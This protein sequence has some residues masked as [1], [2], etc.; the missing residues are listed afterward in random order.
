MLQE[1]VADDVLIVRPVESVSLLGEYHHV[2]PFACLL[3]S[4]GHADGRSDGHV[5]VHLASHEQ[6]TTLQVLGQF[7]GRGYRLAVALVGLSPPLD[8]SGV[9][10]IARRSHTYL[11]EVGIGKHGGDSLKA[12]AAVAVDAN[13]GGVDEAVLP[14]QRLDGVLV[15]GY[16]VVAQVAIA[17][18]VEVAVAQGRRAARLDV[19][20]HKT[21]LGQ[22]LVAV[23]VDGERAGYL[24]VLWTGIDVGDDGK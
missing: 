14:G 13:A 15:V 1:V 12:A 2:E 10:V 21:Q 20:D 9:V 17:V 22:R 18:G 3:Q 16:R 23:L 6:Q 11:V 7:H 19:D 5:L 8:V 4:I 24:V